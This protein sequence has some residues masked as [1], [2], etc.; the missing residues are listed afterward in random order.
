MNGVCIATSARK[1]QRWQSPSHTCSR[2]PRNARLIMAS[3][4]IM[5]I[6][7]SKHFLQKVASVAIAVS[8]TRSMRCFACHHPNIS[9]HQGAIGFSRVIWFS[10]RSSSVALHTVGPLFLH[11][12]WI[13]EQP[14]RWITEQP[15][16]WDLWTLFFDQA[17]SLRLIFRL[18][19][20]FLSNKD[21]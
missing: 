20:I 19:L 15:H 18:Y 3:V 21:W 9:S 13:T 14:I 4:M 2:C 17:S 1:L 7:R 10:F 8:W 6:I 5:F 11:C 16:A 12:R